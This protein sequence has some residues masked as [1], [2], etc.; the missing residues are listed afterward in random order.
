MKTISKT[1]I[2]KRLQEKE[3]PKLRRLIILL[4]KQK[5]PFWH[6][7]AKE[8]AR[9]KRKTSE[10]NLFKINKHAKDKETV[11]IPGKVLS[12][13]SISKQVRIAAFSFSSKAREKIKHAGG[14]AIE[15]EEL[16]KSPD[17]TVRMIR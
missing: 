3:N 2:E 1:K 14:N 17:K 12:S 4:K 9:P 13:G 6:Q 11:I 8:L 7:V 10:V 5:Q 16:L 15:I